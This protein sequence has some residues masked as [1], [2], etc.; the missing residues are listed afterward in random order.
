MLKDSSVYRIEALV[1]RANVRCASLGA[2]HSL[3]LDQSGAV[4][5]CGENKEVLVQP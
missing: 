4:W 1:G 2:H 3:F 5:S